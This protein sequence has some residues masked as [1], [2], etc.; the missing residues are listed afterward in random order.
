[1]GEAGDG[2]VK[3]ITEW[4]CERRPTRREVR[5]RR[6]S[7]RA[8]ATASTTTTSTTCAPTPACDM[9]AK[10]IKQAKSTDPQAVALALEGMKVRSRHR[11]G[12][13]AQGRPPADPA[14]VHLDASAKSAAK[15]GP[16]DV[17]VRPGEHRLRLQDRRAASRPTSSAQPTSCQMKRPLSSAICAIAEP[18]AGQTAR[19]LLVARLLIRFLHP[20]PWNSS[21]ISTAERRVLRAAAVHAVLGPDADLQHDGRAQF[22]ARQLLH[23]RRLL[24]LPDQRLRSASGRRSSLAPLL[25]GALGA[26]VERYG[27]R[28]VHKLRPRRRAAVHLRP[29]LPDRGDR[30]T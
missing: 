17:E 23:A 21:S 28:T 16:K 7:P 1:M 30:C 29:R 10:A 24:R 25:V 2:K 6:L 20:A 11:R 26:L 12:R 4:H 13:D 22:R 27:L 5:R 3:Q 15:G 9:L 19:P 8:T 14:A 18:T